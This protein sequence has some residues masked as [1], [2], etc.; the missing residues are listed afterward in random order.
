MDDILAEFV[1]E[2]LDSIDLLDAEIV[3]LERDPS[4]QAA[5]ERIFRVVHTI[6][7]TCGFLNL[8]RLEHLA[9]AIEHRIAPVRDGVPVAAGRVAGIFPLLDRLRFVVVGIGSSGREPEGDDG[10]LLPDRRLVPASASHDTH[11]A[12]VDHDGETGSLVYQVLRRPLLAGEV[13]LDELERVFRETPGLDD[14]S[15]PRTDVPA[16]EARIIK[17]RV[18]VAVDRLDHLID[19]VSEL[20]LVRN[21]LLDLSSKDPG[22]PY[23]LPFQRLS[24]ITGALQDGVM[25]VRMQAVST[26]WAG[27]PRMV[28][29]LALELGKEVELETAGD[30]TEIDRQL[31]EIIKD[32]VVH[33]VR[34]AIDHGIEAPDVRR[35]AGKRAGGT[36]RLT[37]GREGGQIVVRL[38][39]DGLGLNC[40]A[41]R[42]RALARGLASEAECR[43]MS[44][45]EAAM[46]IFRPG[47]STAATVTNVS[48]RGVGLDAVRAA[49]EQA[50]GAIELA[51]RPGHGLDMVLRMPLTLAIASVLIAESAGQRFALPQLAV[52]ELVRVSPDTDIRIETIGSTQALRLRNGLLPLIRLDQALGCA[53][54]A[55]PGIAAICQVGQLRFGLALDAILQTEEIVVKPMPVALRS[56][57]FYSGV[58]ILGDGAVVLILEPAGFAKSLEGVALPR[59][60]ATITPLPVADAATLTRL[61]LFTAGDGRMRAVPLALVT[62]LEEFR[63]SAIERIGGLEL[64]PYRGGTMRLIRHAEAAEPAEGERLPVVVFSYGNT[65]VGLCVLEIV[66]VIEHRLDLDL[67]HA[68]QGCLGTALVEGRLL[69]IIDV[70]SFFD[71]SAQDGAVAPMTARLRLLLAEPSPFFQAM[72]DPLLRGAGY[73]VVL[74]NTGEEALALAARAR[75]DAA[76]V[77]FD[78]S[79]A[80]AVATCAGLRLASMPP[81]CVVGLATRAFAGARLPP[82]A[83]PGAMVGKFDRRKLL[84]VLAASSLPIAVAA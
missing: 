11:G 17:P 43:S 71:V 20:V 69:E 72:L 33:L 1:T 6:K 22:G 16:Q 50:G 38:S 2:T 80:E 64:V 76:I 54:G 40:E 70:A 10:D 47:F 61:L 30:D 48:G 14:Y 58:T 56:V 77:D 81:P 84:E 8:P 60:N 23:K 73:D 82:S 34:N 3:R 21:Q 9:H 42:A 67:A 78:K 29:D 15:A 63:A 75:F 46:L 4:N 41:L 35:A 66:D 44:D 19:V 83:G 55:M 18:R 25:R 28:R 39:D 12:G 79:P 49:V 36:I 68:T 24:H 51:N 65:V 7:G 62:R 32:S 13:A 5:I 74:A 31:L 59:A 37:A 52:S 57:P 27:L 45:G 26:A 53:G